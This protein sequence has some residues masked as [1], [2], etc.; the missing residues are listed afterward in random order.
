MLDTKTI[1]F[2]KTTLAKHLDTKEYKAFIFG[3]HVIGNNR[4]WSDIDIGIE[5]RTKLPPSTYFDLAD[6]FEESN[7]PYKVDL[8]DFTQ[9]TDKF[10]TV[11]LKN[12]LYLT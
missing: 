1:S 2:I 10:K 7:L 3:S 4:R 8:V 9:V 12:T 5:G 11:A 6:A